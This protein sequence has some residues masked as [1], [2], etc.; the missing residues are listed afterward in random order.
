M[1]I[2]VFVVGEVVGVYV[3]EWVIYF[4]IVCFV[5]EVDEEECDGFGGCGW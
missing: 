4:E 5:E 3:D 1:V 2:D